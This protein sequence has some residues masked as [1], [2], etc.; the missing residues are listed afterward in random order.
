MENLTGESGDIDQNSNN[1]NVSLI[2]NQV[3]LLHLDVGRAAKQLRYSN[4]REMGNEAAMRDE[5]RQ[6]TENVTFLA[7]HCWLS[8]C[9]P[10]YV[11]GGE[12]QGKGRKEEEEESFLLGLVDPTDPQKYIYIYID[13]C[14]SVLYIKVRF[15]GEDEE[16]FLL[17]TRLIDPLAQQW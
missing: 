3:L 16:E 11:Y 7:G 17:H 15:G 14:V 10:S 6:E 1:H 8:H 5:H 13:W 4:V 9:L 2:T 12:G